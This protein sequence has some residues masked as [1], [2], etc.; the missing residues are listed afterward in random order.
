MEAE[1]LPQYCEGRV[2]SA[3]ASKISINLNLHFKIIP[4]KATIASSHIRD[5]D[6]INSRASSKAKVN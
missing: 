4:F 6:E 2:I 3:Y 5:Y 1:P